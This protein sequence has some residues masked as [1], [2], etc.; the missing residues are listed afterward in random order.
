MLIIENKLINEQVLNEQFM[1]NLD[2]CKG[3]CC[4]EGDFGAPLETEELYILEAIYEKVKPF[5]S[6]KSIKRIEEKGLFTFFEEPK[7]YGTTLM[8]NTGACV[9]MT[10]DKNGVAKCGIEKAYEHGVIDFKK[11]ISCHMYP[12]RVTQNRK[13]GF[14]VLNYDEWD[15]C[16]AACKKGKD[17]KMPVYRFVKDALVRKYGPEF[18]EELEA[19][20][21]L[22]SETKN[23]E[24]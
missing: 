9:Y 4:W 14:E 3:A 15:I 19:A 16:S 23:T 6:T 12:V 10:F 13:N 2:A 7:E 21:D 8:E 24:E 20:A 17:H 18:Y 5:L 22:F 11:P 1:C